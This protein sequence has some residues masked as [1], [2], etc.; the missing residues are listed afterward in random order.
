L[1][2]RHLHHHQ[3][4]LNNVERASVR[5]LLSFTYQAAEKIVVIGAIHPDSL[6]L[7]TAKCIEYECR[8]NCI[9]SHGQYYILFIS[10]RQLLSSLTVR[11]CFVVSLV[12]K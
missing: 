1:P 4:E 7:P 3:K 8:N 9:H 10:I 12:G 2:P 11:R 5:V 6:H